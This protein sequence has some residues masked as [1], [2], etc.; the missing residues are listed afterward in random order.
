MKNENTTIKS[1]NMRFNNSGFENKTTVFG[2]LNNIN[3]T[4]LS[5]YYLSK[6]LDRVLSKDFEVDELTVQK[7]CRL[8]KTIVEGLVNG[9]NLTHWANNV[10]LQDEEQII[11]GKLR[12]NTFNAADLKMN[13]TFNGLDLSKDVL[14]YD[15]E[16]AVVEGEKTF[17]GA[18]VLN[19]T[20]A[21]GKTIQGVDVDAWRANLLS[22]NENAIFR[23]D[24]VLKNAGFYGPVK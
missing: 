24:L 10:L 15:V 21:K 5:K 4:L 13:G 7:W 8:R 2:Y 11:T 12:F 19:L 6:T 23:G 18:R 1:E 17:L 3:L 16:D 20:I 9:I 22:Q 14:R